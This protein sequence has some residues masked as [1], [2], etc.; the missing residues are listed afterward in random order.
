[1]KKPEKKNMG[2]I[3]LC[4]ARFSDNL[5]DAV[6]SDCMYY[7]L[8]K[9]G[10]RDVVHLD[11]SGRVEW[12]LEKISWLKYFILKLPAS[13]RV[14]LFLVNW[15]FRGRAKLLSSLRDCVQDH[16]VVVFGGG[17]L[18]LDNDWIFPIKIDLISRYAK[19]KG[20]AVGFVG[21]G[22]GTKFGLVSKLIYESIF[23]RENTKYIS[24]RDERS[25]TL[26]NK[27]FST[28]FDP[29]LT[30]D[31]A[32]YA[33]EAYGIK[34]E[35]AL[36]SINKIGL[37]V[38]NS[39]ELG[40]AS[41][42]TQG[43]DQRILIDGWRDLALLLVRRGF[44]VAFY[45]NGSAEDEIFKTGLSNLMAGEGVSFVPRP[46]SPVEL[47]ETIGGFDLLVAHRL[48][49]SIIAASLGVRAIGL[50][51]DKKVKSFYELTGVGDLCVQGDVI[52]CDEIVSMVSG[53]NGFD[54]SRINVCKDVIVKNIIECLNVVLKD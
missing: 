33:D 8:A 23:S 16:D 14:V 52:R 18:I 3:V 40:L 10:D 42:E 17:Q 48:H 43:F 27:F 54:R 9:Y 45:T 30:Y 5:G 19:D 7:L 21:C 41:G 13:F 50:S 12:S 46:K 22:V 28:N 20:V 4:T 53:C 24:L 34:K 38:A 31:A 47:V 15:I 36:N 37:C 51:W 39:R 35:L 26:F 2:K 25:I 29:V 49:S 6:I 44:V 11:I 32:L 1:M